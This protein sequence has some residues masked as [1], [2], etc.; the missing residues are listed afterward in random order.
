MCSWF[1]I[2]EILV[3]SLCVSTS[4][5]TSYSIDVA[6]GWARL[7]SS[8]D[9]EKETFAAWE[10]TG[11]LLSVRAGFGTTSTGIGETKIC[12]FE[13]VWSLCSL[14]KLKLYTN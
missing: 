6:N 1:L 5:F 3:S 8:W 4:E 2:G 11:V 13:E 7:T 10:I 12:V 14:D 9:N